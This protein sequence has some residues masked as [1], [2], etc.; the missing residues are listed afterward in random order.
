MDIL[1]DPLYAVYAEKKGT[2]SPSK[3]RPV[4]RQNYGKILTAEELEKRKKEIKD[5]MSC[6][7]CDDR[8]LKWQVPDNPFGQTWDNDFMY[9]CFNDECP[10]YVRGWDFMCNNGNHGVSYRLM[11]NPVNDCSMPIPV[12]SP[13]SLREGIVSK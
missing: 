10:Y 9:I 1:S 3:T 6:P 11:Y 7:Y 12:Q 13:K 2:I 8:L 5:T 4:L